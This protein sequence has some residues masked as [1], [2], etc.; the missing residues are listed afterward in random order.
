MWVHVLTPPTSFMGFD[1]AFE[2][3]D[4]AAFVEMAAVVTYAGL[5]IAAI[6]SG[7]GEVGNNLG[8]GGFASTSKQRITVKKA[9]VVNLSIGVGKRISVDYEEW[10][11][12]KLNTVGNSMVLD[13]GPLGDSGGGQF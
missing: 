6:V 13:L 8:P 11:I 7:V 10:R 5:P 9:D 1:A 3:S 2:L 12:I 4:D